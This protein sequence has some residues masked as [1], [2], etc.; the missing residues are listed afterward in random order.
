[1]PGLE[2]DVVQAYLSFANQAQ[3]DCPAYDRLAR[4]VS[5]DADLIQRLTTL[6][7]PKRQPNLLFGVTKLLGGPQADYPE[8]AQWVRLRWNNVVDEITRRRTQTNE[9]GRCATLLPVL[10]EAGRPLALL[11]VGASA[12][13]TLYPDRYRYAYD[14]P[15]G[16]LTLGDDPNAP[17]LVCRAGP[18]VQIPSTLPSVTWRAGLDLNPLDVSDPDTLAWLAALIWPGQ[19]EREDRLR[20]AAQIVAADPPLLV[21]GDLLTDLPALA[22]QAP[23]DAQLVI[24]HTAV[25]AYVDPDARA[26]FSEIAMRLVADGAVWISNEGAAVM[27]PKS[28]PDSLVARARGRF[29]LSVNGAPRYF[30]GGHGQS[31]DLV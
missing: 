29:V 17:E 24:Q 9:A 19:P 7:P 21:T 10:A 13:L 1:M 31:I 12:G 25:L 23:A 11:E 28:A 30:T 20:R 16:P 4:A 2:A 6:P 8:F 27:L 18:G 26:E 14:T 15:G 5:N 3:E 22:A